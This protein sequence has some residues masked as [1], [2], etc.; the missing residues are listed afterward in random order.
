MSWAAKNEKLVRPQR[1]GQ[2]RP[3]PREP[4]RRPA[5]PPR[6]PT[7][8]HLERQGSELDVHPPRREGEG[9]LRRRLRGAP[10]G[11]SL[12][13]SPSI[14]PPSPPK[15]WSTPRSPV[16]PAPNSHSFFLLHVMQKIPDLS[17]ARHVSKIMAGDPSRGAISVSTEVEIPVGSYLLVSPPFPSPSSL[18]N[19][20]FSPL[21]SSST[22]PLQAPSSPSSSPPARLSP[23]SPPSPSRPPTLSRISQKKRRGRKGKR[24]RRLGGSG[25]RVRTAWCCRGGGGRVGCV[26]MRGSS[27]LLG[28]EGIG[29]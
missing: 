9:V 5:T 1:E 18:T 8:T 27:L 26:G 3:H 29:G 13:P 19:P 22:A 15:H 16:P 20:S 28:G 21:P 7:T 6:R 25:R 14:P 11:S 10:R 17:L 2:H 4:K 12:S 23:P 24:C